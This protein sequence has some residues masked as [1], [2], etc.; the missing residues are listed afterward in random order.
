MKKLLMLIKMPLLS[1][2]R[3]RSSKNKK[4]KRLFNTFDR[5]LRNKHNLLNNKGIY[6]FIQKNKI[7]EGKRNPKI[8]IT[9]IKSFG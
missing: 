1:S 8:E 7:G 9:P 3:E 2:N 6:I 4:K 5:K